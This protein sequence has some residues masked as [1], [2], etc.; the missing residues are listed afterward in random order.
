M[1]IRTLVHK[2]HSVLLW[3][4][5]IQY[6]GENNSGLSHHISAFRGRSVRGRF[7]VGF[8]MVLYT[9]CV[10]ELIPTVF[11]G[12]ALWTFTNNYNTFVLHTFKA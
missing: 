11:A 2:V 6:H 3:C 8:H 5:N 7:P 4:L 1:G 10:L 9:Y 12:E